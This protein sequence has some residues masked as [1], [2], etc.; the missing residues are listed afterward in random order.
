MLRGPLVFLR[1][2]YPCELFEQQ[3]LCRDQQQPFA[4]LMLDAVLFFPQQPL[5]SEP[6]QQ[7]LPSCFAHILPFLP[8]QQVEDACLSCPS[9]LQQ[10]MS[11]PSQQDID[12]AASASLPWQQPI[13]G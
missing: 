8:W 13:D 3:C 1:A 7:C 9:F 10:G 11:L 12:W 4:S 2:D 6:S 5:P